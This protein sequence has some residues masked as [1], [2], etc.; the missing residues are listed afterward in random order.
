LHSKQR[1]RDTESQ[2]DQNAEHL[3]KVKTHIRAKVEHPF[4]VIKWL[5]G[6]VKS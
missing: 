4:R 2:G 1:F 6:H 3:E 5:F